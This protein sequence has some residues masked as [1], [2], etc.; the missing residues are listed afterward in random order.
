MKSKRIMAD[1]EDY[2]IDSLK[3]PEEAAGYLIVALEEYSKDH[4][5]DSL[6]S[7]LRYI[8]AA[9]NL[10]LTPLQKIPD[11]SKLDNVLKESLKLEWNKVLEA[12]EIDYSAI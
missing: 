12:L 4:D 5:I 6:L 1:F 10:L 9:K 7:S 11:T 3:E 8:T 2:L